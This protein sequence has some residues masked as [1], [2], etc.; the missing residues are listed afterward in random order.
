MTR[1]PTRKTSGWTN[2][3]RRAGPQVPEGA[4][5][6]QRAAAL[7]GEGYSVEQIATELKISEYTAYKL[8]AYAGNAA[9]RD[10]ERAEK[11]DFL[12]KIA[13]EGVTSPQ[14]AR[15]MECHPQSVR[16]FALRYGIVFRKAKTRGA[17]VYED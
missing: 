7:F 16:Q 4:W 11:I 8:C 1:H 6:R 15:Y 10:R 9:K 12:Q 2:S 3:N 13:A 17:A 5:R 14:A